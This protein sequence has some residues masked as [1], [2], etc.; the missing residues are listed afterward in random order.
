MQEVWHEL[1]IE[2]PETET[3]YILSDLSWSGQ[4]AWDKI[5]PNI[6]AFLKT[7][8]LANLANLDNLLQIL[9]G[10]TLPDNL[11]EVLAS[12]KCHALENLNHLARWFAV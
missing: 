11:I 5:T 3:H 10:S 6:Y 4:W 8:E 12:R 9:Q 2:T 7:N 1:S